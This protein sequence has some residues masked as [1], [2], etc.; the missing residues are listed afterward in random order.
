MVRGTV[1][2]PPFLE[3]LF[4][5]LGWGWIFLLFSKVIAYGLLSAVLADDP[6]M[7]L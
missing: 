1:C 3:N 7:V 4:S 6:K 2:P 5:V